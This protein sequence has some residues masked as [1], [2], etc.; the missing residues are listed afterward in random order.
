MPEVMLRK[1]VST[2]TTTVH[3]LP[4]LPS[5]FA[6]VIVYETGYCAHVHI[7]AHVIFYETGYLAN[8]SISAHEVVAQHVGNYGY[9]LVL[10]ASPR[11]GLFYQAYA[12][13]EG[14][15]IGRYKAT[16]PFSSLNPTSSSTSAT[17]Q[18]SSL[19]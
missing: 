13:T 10:K 8:T 14:R 4:H 7:D 11:Q 12:N 19:M 1:A 3:R 5:S 15:K 16:A 17:A 9:S 18:Y 2:Q 6:H